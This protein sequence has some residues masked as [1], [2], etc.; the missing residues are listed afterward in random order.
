MTKGARQLRRNLIAN[1]TQLL[2]QSALAVN[3]SFAAPLRAVLHGGGS[4]Q[5]SY[6]QSR[7]GNAWRG[8]GKNP[9]FNPNPGMDRMDRIRSER[10]SAAQDQLQAY[11]IL[12]RLH[13][14]GAAVPLDKS[15]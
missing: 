15:V 2:M 5:T 12:S 8:W 6:R 4:C 10:T 11:V 13:F 9:G 7:D 1:D 14:E 3:R